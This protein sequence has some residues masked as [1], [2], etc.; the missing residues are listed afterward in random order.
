MTRS[1]QY[2]PTQVTGQVR[3]AIVGS[4]GFADLQQVRR[5][6]W[7]LANRGSVEIVSGGA[8]G[9]DEEARRMAEVHHMP[10]TEFPADWATHGKRAGFVRNQQIV[11]YADRIVAFWDGESPGTKSTIDLALKA[12]KPVE[13]R[14]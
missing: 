10:Y 11:D 6:I 7:S 14:F 13:V 12:R 2:P 9:V 5:L 1:E 8:R 4:R 3:V